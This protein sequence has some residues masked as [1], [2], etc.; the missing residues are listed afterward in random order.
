MILK[1]MIYDSLIEIK[2]A[3]MIASYVMMTYTFLLIILNGR[4]TWTE[5]DTLI[6]YAEGFFL[7]LSW[8]GFFLS[9]L[10]S[11]RELRK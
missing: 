10:K 7:A 6:L 11:L 5:P 1:Q 3:C 8:I 4:C 9:S 2:K